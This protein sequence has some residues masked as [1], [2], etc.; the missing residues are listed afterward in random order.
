MKTT[1]FFMMLVAA[2]GLM[3]LSATATAGAFSTGACQ[4]CHKV[5]KDSVG[6]SLK[7]VAEKYGDAKALA[8]VFKS[9][10]K[11]EDRKVAQSV[12]KWKSQAGT[13][14]GQYDN[15]IKKGGNEEAAAEA[16]F[17]VVKAGKF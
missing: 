7:E 4:A 15:L 2:A 3:G 12:A 17:A 8:A 10:F 11:V 16:V 5:D 9:G 1:K 13:M 14:T 6:P